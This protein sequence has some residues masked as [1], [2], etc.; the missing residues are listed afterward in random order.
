MGII[1]GVN[2]P[3]KYK[4]RAMLSAIAVFSGTYV[5]LMKKVFAVAKEM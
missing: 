4:N 5:P 1:I 3:E 2:M